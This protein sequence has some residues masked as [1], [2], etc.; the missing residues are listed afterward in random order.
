MKGVSMGGASIRGS[1]GAVNLDL[2]VNRTK[3]QQTFKSPDEEALNLIEETNEGYM[4][5][6]GRR[7]GPKSAS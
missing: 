7:S 3:K 5:Q 1:T 2:K 4:S 6:D